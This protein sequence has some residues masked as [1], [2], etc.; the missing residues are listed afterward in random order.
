MKRLIFNIVLFLVVITCPWWV[1]VVLGL[2]ILY[3]LKSYNELIIFG[4]V[5]DIYYGNFSQN[6]SILEYKFTLLFL[7]LIVSSFFIKKRLRF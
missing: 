4:L 5:M 1:G 3:Y 2:F 6:F 7:I